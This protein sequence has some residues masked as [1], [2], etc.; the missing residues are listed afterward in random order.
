M[1]SDCDRV[2]G[3]NFQ[4]YDISDI[5]L[6]LVFTAIDPADTCTRTK[7]P[8]HQQRVVCVRFA[9]L[10]TGYEDSVAVRSR[11]A[12]IDVI[13]AGILSSTLHSHIRFKTNADT[14]T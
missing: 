3:A 5:Y 2:M 9:C 4:Q 6:V 13:K 14:H 12:F 7:V 11:E 1:E 10:G 8:F